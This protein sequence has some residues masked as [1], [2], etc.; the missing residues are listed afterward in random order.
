MRVVYITPSLDDVINQLCN[1]VWSLMDEE[2]TLEH[3]PGSSQDSAMLEEQP[4]NKDIS[5]G[6]LETLEIDTIKEEACEIR[7]E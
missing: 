7:N 4:T 2:P 1:N 3:P 6:F 5:H